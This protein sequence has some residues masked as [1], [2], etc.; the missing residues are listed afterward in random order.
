[1]L[2][3]PRYD[4]PPILSIGGPPEVQHA[5]VVRQR[6]RLEATL[7]DLS[8]DDW[9]SPSRCEGWTV[10]DVVAHLVGVN[11]FWQSSVLAGLAGTPTPCLSG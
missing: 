9:R 11:A 1:M 4:G 6:R 8:D 2:L 5:A 7:A 10:Q 3:S